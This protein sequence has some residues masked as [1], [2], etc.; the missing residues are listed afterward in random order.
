M[1]QNNLKH[2]RIVG[3]HPG[4]SKKEKLWE[5]EKFAEVVDY[6][7]L[8]GYQPVL[9]EGPGDFNTVRDIILK[10]NTKPPRVKTS[11]KNVVAFISRC[12][13]IICL[14]SSAVHIAAA[15]G[16][17]VIALYGPQSPD[18]TKP[19]S[20]NIEIIW[21]ENLHC[22]PCEYGKCKY[23]FNLCMQSISSDQVINKIDKFLATV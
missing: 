15:V 11:L 9:I 13:L 1:E 5:Y 22:R 10:C 21:N 8:K 23:E 17:P 12:K 16:T 14:D 2:H 19:F 3:I 6:L 20:N 18:Y 4:A 7:S